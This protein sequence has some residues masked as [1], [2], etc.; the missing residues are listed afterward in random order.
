MS[1]RRIGSLVAGLMLCLP[2]L[3]AGQ[4]YAGATVGAGGAQVPVGSITG[5]FRGALRLYGGYEFGP[6]VAAEVMTLDLGTPTN[7]GGANA[8]ST[9]GAFGVAAVGTIPVQRWRFS[10]RLGVLSMD[11]RISKTEV[12]RSPQGMFALGVGFDVTRK[13]I[14]GLESAVS[15]VQ[16]GPP[17]NDTARVNWTAF[18]TTYRF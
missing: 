4:I 14:L 7:A 18:T 5:G 17:I 11:G 12:T 1:T 13:L 8:V 2:A 15:H 3:C 6:H 10:G 16:F 9:I